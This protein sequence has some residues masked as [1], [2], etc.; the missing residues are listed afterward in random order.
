[1]KKAGCF[2]GLSLWQ[3][4]Q[5]QLLCR[6]LLK[7]NGSFH[8]G[9]PQRLAAGTLKEV[10]SVTIRMDVDLNTGAAPAHWAFHLLL[11]FVMF[12]PL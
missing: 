11:S 5:R 10:V 1:M 4:C 12:Y 6:F 8:V 2:A 9:N 7:K 3:P